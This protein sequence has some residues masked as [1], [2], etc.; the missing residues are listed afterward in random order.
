M[1]RLMDLAWLEN[2]PLRILPLLVERNNLSTIEV[3]TDIF[4]PTLDAIFHKRGNNGLL[5]SY[6]FETC[7]A[8]WT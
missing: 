4:S 8:A 3:R 7:C 5:C 1:F 2:T 6:N